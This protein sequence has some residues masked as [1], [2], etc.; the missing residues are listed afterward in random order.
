VPFDG[1]SNVMG[2]S[3]LDHRFHASPLAAP[4]EPVAASA[5][6]RESDDATGMASA[7]VDSAV[8]ARS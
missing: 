3:P 6:S 1:N 4:T 8:A 5:S 7:S 2:S